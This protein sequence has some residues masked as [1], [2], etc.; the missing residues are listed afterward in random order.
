M[1]PLKIALVAAETA[2]FAKTGGLA[3]VLTGLC[4]HL[5]RQGH[6]APES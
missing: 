6:D 3:D 5:H 2:P 4:R 1:R